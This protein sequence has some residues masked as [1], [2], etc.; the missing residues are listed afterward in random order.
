[1]PIATRADLCFNATLRKMV[2][3]EIL[4]KQPRPSTSWTSAFGGEATRRLQPNLATPSALLIA[5]AI[6]QVVWVHLSFYLKN[7]HNAAST[8]LRI[9][10]QN[11]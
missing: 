8:N 11:S 6:S 9:Q 3:R 4:M 10:F 2:D 1:M 5:S 7:I